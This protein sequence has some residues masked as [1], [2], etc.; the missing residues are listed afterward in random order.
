MIHGKVLPNFQFFPPIPITSP[1][2]MHRYVNVNF[3]FVMV[4][5]VMYLNLSSKVAT[6]LTITIRKCGTARV[7]A[8]DTTANIGQASRGKISYIK[9]LFKAATSLL[10]PLIFSP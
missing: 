10:Q 7:V 1:R 8:T 2:H 9:H 5:M 6:K 3:I 4:A